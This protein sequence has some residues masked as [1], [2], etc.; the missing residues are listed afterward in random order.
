MK[1]AAF[2]A[3][4][5]AAAGLRRAQRAIALAAKRK[6]AQAFGLTIPESFLLG[7]DAVLE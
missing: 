7:G 5:A 4:R 2:T 3:V 6:T 1:R